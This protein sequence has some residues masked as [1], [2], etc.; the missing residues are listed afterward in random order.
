MQQR[1]STRTLDRWKKREK[2]T[3]SYSALVRSS[4]PCKIDN[5]ETLLKE[6]ESKPTLYQKDLAKKYGVSQSTISL[7]LKRAKISYKKNLSLPRKR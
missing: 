3:G 2:E 4:K 5:P 6:L 7:S 1:L